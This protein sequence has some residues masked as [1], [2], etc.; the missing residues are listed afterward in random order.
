M[1]Q[2]SVDSRSIKN[3]RVMLEKIDIGGRMLKESETSH[4]IIRRSALPIK[5]QN[6]SET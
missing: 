5:I 3:S 2:P 1:R 4:K 6:E